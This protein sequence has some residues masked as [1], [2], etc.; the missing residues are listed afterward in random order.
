MASRRLDY[1]IFDADTFVDECSAL[2]SA[3][4]ANVMGG[5]LGR[6]MKTPAKKAA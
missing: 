6:L 3:D 4:V 2:P 1:P 5:H